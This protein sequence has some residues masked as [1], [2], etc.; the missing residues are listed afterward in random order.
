VWFGLYEISGY[1]NGEPSF[2][3]P[4]KKLK[5]VMTHEKFIYYFAK[6]LRLN[7]ICKK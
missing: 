7:S 2:L 6:P 1:A 5:K 3:I 4:L